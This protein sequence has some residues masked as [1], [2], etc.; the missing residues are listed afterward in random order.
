M[1]QLT[2]GIWIVEIVFKN[3]NSGSKFP[4]YGVQALRGRAQRLPPAVGSKN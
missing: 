2:G 4:N 3:V 1:K